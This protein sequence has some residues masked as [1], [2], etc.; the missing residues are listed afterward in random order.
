MRP[1]RELDT[2]IAREIFGHE[3]WASNKTVHEKTT[4]GTKRPLRSYSREMEWA[5]EVAK[6]MRVTLVP[7]ADGQWFA[8]VAAQSGWESPESFAAFLQKGDFSTC[9]ASIGTD[10]PLLICE[11]AIRAHDKWVALK[12]A[13]TEKESAR[14]TAPEEAQLLQ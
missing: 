5:W 11:A 1:G 2:R 10:A 4:D 8:F 6:V 3:V 9:G 14:E 7:L 13:Q 12:D